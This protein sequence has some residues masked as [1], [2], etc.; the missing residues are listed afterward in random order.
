MPD[1]IAGF[2][3]GK[4]AAR[5]GAHRRHTL[6]EP[7]EP[8]EQARLAQEAER[9]ARE[10][11]A[12][13]AAAGTPLLDRTG[14]ARSPITLA[15]YRTGRAPAN[16][17]QSY[18]AE[19]LTT[20]EVMAILAALPS[21]GPVGVRNRA[22][23]VV[24]W[25]VGLRVTEALSLLPKDLDLELGAVTVLHGKGDKP[26]TVAMD[27]MTRRY[28]Q[29][30]LREREKVA[31]PPAR[32][33]L[34]PLFC[35]VSLDLS[36]P[37]RPVQAATVREMLKRYARK[38]GVTKR[39]HPHGLRHT[40]AFELSEAGVPVPHIQNQ[41]G[42]ED[43]AMTQLYLNHLRPSHLFRTIG[44][45]PGPG[46][47]FP[48]EEITTSSALSGGAGAP[49]SSPPSPLLRMQPPEPAVVSR[50]TTGDRRK[51]EERRQLVLDTLASNG[52]SATQAQ[53]RRT[54]GMQRGQLLA[55]LHALND[56]RLIQRTGLD[57]NRSV[58]WKLSPPPV[59]MRRR[60]ELR[61]PRNGEGP[62][63]VLDAIEGLDGRASQA[64]IARVLELDPETVRGH[65]ATLEAEGRI[66]RAGLDRSTSRRGSQLWKLAPQ[67]S[68]YSSGA[69][70]YSMRLT[71]R[72]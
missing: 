45:R 61:C 16:K 26:R 12:T 3:A 49:T 2:S 1:Q 54:L 55:H 37:G 69:A 10:I 51:T 63:R 66:V 32:A 13:A 72:A 8:E 35:T 20:E 27:R 47:E 11:I 38:A 44:D 28:L 53:L 43:L 6:A 23:V 34:A 21:A 59:V 52:G 15:E 30:W 46:D 5:R 56:E 24:M 19:V 58:I 60:A 17:G 42:H 67:Q 7:P 40:C 39:V 14:R 22:L 29:L 62:L 18:P 31:I 33:A 36:G 70:G 48:H 65:C 9:T 25:R 64:D 4:S 68:R 71:V 50:P 57:R 41:L